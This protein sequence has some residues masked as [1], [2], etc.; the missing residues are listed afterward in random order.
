MATFGTRN[1]AVSKEQPL[2]DFNKVK[3]KIIGQDRVLD[4]LIKSMTKIKYRNFANQSNGRRVGPLFSAF[5]AG[6][7]G[8]GKTET[9]YEIANI[10]H[11]G[12]N[13]VLRVDCAEFQSEHEVARL[14]GAPPGYL[15][16]RETQPLLSQARINA[17]ASENCQY[18]I[19]LFDEFEK[20]ARSLQRLLLGVLDSG[21]MRL[22]DNNQVNFERCL[23]FFSS[24][25]GSHEAVRKERNFITGEMEEKSPYSE[26]ALLPILKKTFPPE[27]I[28]RLDFTGFYDKITPFFD[29]IFDKLLS[30]YIQ[31]LGVGVAMSSRVRT[32]TS[33]IYLPEISVTPA[34]YERVKEECNFTDFGAR[35]LKKY[36][37]SEIF[38]P[39]MDVLIE[40]GYLETGAFTV[41]GSNRDFTEVKKIKIGCKKKGISV[42]LVNG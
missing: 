7:T 1:N 25:I 39:I 33:D 30:E 26:S 23:I 34:V 42:E 31:S 4:L 14:I 11:K 3:E 15:G 8:V 19:I 20:A 36:I 37:F 21:T 29:K 41:G 9:V 27:F 17:V 5:L 6:P 35:I 12:S 2:V 32:I 18:S 16:H 38:S 22:G 13:H 40:E 10:M 28:G 24:N